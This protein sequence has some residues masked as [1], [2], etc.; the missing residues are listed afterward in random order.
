MR[1]ACT[2]LPSP[3]SP[4]IRRPPVHDDAKELAIPDPRVERAVA[5]TRLLLTRWRER[6]IAIR[7]DAVNA[8]ASC[9]IFKLVSNHACLL[10]QS[11]GTGCGTRLHRG[12]SVGGAG[13]TQGDEEAAGW[14]LRC[15]MF[16]MSC[17]SCSATTTATTRTWPTIDSASAQPAGSQVD[18]AQPKL[19][20]ARSL[21]GLRRGLG[22]IRPALRCFC[23][24]RRRFR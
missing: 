16:W 7:A 11:P 15:R 2:T 18:R 14:S 10:L 24:R 23:G 6:P 4:R 12:E 13:R 19:G 9:E 5:R 3:T 17:A 8:Q 21:Q 22:L 1:T 20:P